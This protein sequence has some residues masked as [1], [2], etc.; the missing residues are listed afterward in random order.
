MADRSQKRRENKKAQRGQRPT[1]KA[2]GKTA[3][4][5][6]IRK[7]LELYGYEELGGANAETLRHLMMALYLEDETGEVDGNEIIALLRE[8][9]PDLPELPLAVATNYMRGEKPAHA[10][11]TFDSLLEKW[12]QYQAAEGIRETRATLT[13]ALGGVELE[14]VLWQEELDLAVESDQYEQSEK[15]AKRNLERWPGDGATLNSLSIAR[16]MEGKLPQALQAAREAYKADPKEV[17]FQVNLIRMLTLLGK[18]AEAAEV[19]K[20][21]SL[22]DVGEDTPWATIAEGFALLNRHADVV[23]ALEKSPEPD[24][25][26]Q[27]VGAVAKAR[28]GHWDEAIALWEKALA[29]EAD[30][31]ASDNL[32]NAKTA[33]EERWPAWYFPADSWLTLPQIEVLEGED[34][35][36]DKVLKGEFKIA[37][38]NVLEHGCPQSSG[39]VL[40]YLMEK[41]QGVARQML[42]TFAKGEPGS[43]A[44]R[45]WLVDALQK[46]PAQ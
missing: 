10:I 42:E 8:S 2:Q 9:F 5:P 30:E 1:G 15:L 36:T 40:G 12:P 46:E 23:T 26:L 38:E 44:I 4:Y 39:S 20:V 45:A 41:P 35:P 37:L 3:M 24:A 19:G 18:D 21:L 17:F 29:Q 13:E 25:F 27:H 32:I 11:V 6:K 22:E 16:L 14:R 31:T 43:P 34:D 7:F 33:V 28:L